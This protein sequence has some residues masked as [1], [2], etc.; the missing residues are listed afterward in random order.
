MNAADYS[1]AF[2]EGFVILQSYKSQEENSTREVISHRVAEE[3]DKLLKLEDYTDDQKIIANDLMENVND[4]NS[5]LE[6]PESVI[7][8][9]LDLIAFFFLIVTLAESVRV[10]E[11]TLRRVGK[12]HPKKAF[13][14][15]SQTRQFFTRHQELH[16]NFRIDHHDDQRPPQDQS[17]EGEVAETVAHLHGE[18]VC[19]LEESS[20]HFR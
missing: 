9:N 12:I 15:S 5:H 14:E 10:A 8:V 2:L 20:I 7:N 1:R 13:M 6:L 17:G 18:A 16:R 3:I 11:Q 4:Y 19:Q